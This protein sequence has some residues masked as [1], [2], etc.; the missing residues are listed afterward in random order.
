MR[1]CR[2]CG[3]EALPPKRGL[4]CREC[5]NEK[6][7][8]RVAERRKDPEYLE[9]QRRLERERNRKRYAEDPEFRAKKLER[10]K[11]RRLFYDRGSLSQTEWEGLLSLYNGLC[12]YCPQE[13]EVID[14]VVPMASGGEHSISNVVPAC[15]ACNLSKGDAPLILWG[16]R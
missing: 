1:L 13:A 12:A 6:E 5:R 9:R 7:R 4:I 2:F 16:G 15:S 14:H 11:N 10:T 8:V 3:A